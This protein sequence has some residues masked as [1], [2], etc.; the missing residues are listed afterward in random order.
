MCPFCV[1]TL[2]VLLAGAVSAGGLAALALKATHTEE[3]ARD[4]TPNDPLTEP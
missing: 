1:A 2:G 3:R 4:A